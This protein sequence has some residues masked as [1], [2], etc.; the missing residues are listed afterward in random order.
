M[1]TQI[2]DHHLNT[3]PRATKQSYRRANE[4][5][6]DLRSEQSFQTSQSSMMGRS[7]FSSAIKKGPVFLNTPG[8]GHTSVHDVTSSASQV[9][10]EDSFANAEYNAM[11]EELKT[12]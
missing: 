10:M 2:A 5:I 3:D 4:D 11:E 1:N 12:R 8:M 7:N 9:S 6:D